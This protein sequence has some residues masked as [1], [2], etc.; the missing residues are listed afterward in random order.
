MQRWLH[1]QVKAVIL[2]H[3]KVTVSLCCCCLVLCIGRS[4]FLSHVIIADILLSEISLDM[5]IVTEML[6]YN[7]LCLGERQT[8]RGRER[9]RGEGGKG[10]CDGDT[11]KE[12]KESSFSHNLKSRFSTLS[13]TFLHSAACHSADTI[14]VLL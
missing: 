5:S 14:S 3:V 10:G 12:R 8:E 2:L 1:A 6:G 9:E 7:P 11:S 13:S 4:M